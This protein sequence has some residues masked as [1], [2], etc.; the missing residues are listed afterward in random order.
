MLASPR[1][2]FSPFSEQSDVYTLYS[3]NV[4]EHAVDNEVLREPSDRPNKKARVGSEFFSLPEETEHEQES[5]AIQLSLPEEELPST[6]SYLLELPELTSPVD[7]ISSAL[8]KQQTWREPVKEVHIVSE[9]QKIPDAKS[10]HRDIWLECLDLPQ[11]T[12]CLIS[13]DSREAKADIQVPSPYITEASIDAFDRIC[14]RDLEPNHPTQYHVVDNKTLMRNLK[15]VAIGN[16][17][18]LFFF[19]EQQ[20]QFKPRYLNLRT[21][22]LSGK[23]FERCA[24]EFM[25]VGSHFRNMQ[26]MIDR[27]RKHPSKYGQTGI[28]FVCALSEQLSHL[29]A[30]ILD[31][32]EDQLDIPSTGILS[33][34]MGLKNLFAI[35]QRLAE[36]CQSN[37]EDAMN[38]PM[39]YDIPFGSKLLTNLYEC[40]S[41]TDFS[42]PE[43]AHFKTLM[44]ELLVRSS[45]PYF[46]I[47]QQ[48]LGGKADNGGWMDVGMDFN[49]IDPHKEF[50]IRQTENPSDD[51]EYELAGSESTPTFI[52]QGLARHL[53]AAG[54]AYRILQHL[55]KEQ[56]LSET[57]PMIDLRWAFDTEAAAGVESSLIHRSAFQEA[58][59]SFTV[60]TGVTL[61]TDDPALDNRAQLPVKPNIAQF[62]R[63]FDNSLDTVMPIQ[64]TGGGEELT[65]PTESLHLLSI[66]SD[67]AIHGKSTNIDTLATACTQSIESSLRHHAEQD[68]T[69]MDLPM[70]VASELSVERALLWR[71]QQINQKLFKSL[72]E[73]AMLMHHLDTIANHFLLRDGEFVV[74]LKEALFSNEVMVNQGNALSPMSRAAV[75]LRLGFYV[76]KSWPPLGQGL[77]SQLKSVL[78][79]YEASQRVSFRIHRSDTLPNDPKDFHATDFLLLHYD[80]PFPIDR[81]LTADVI[82]KLN[83]VFSHLIRLLRAEAVVN[84]MYKHVRWLERHRGY[85]LPQHTKAQVFVS[86]QRVISALSEA[87]YRVDIKWNALIERIKATSRLPSFEILSSDLQ[88]CV[89]AMLHTHDDLT[90]ILTMAQHLAR[91]LRQRQNDYPDSQG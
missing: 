17:C 21:F 63:P 50:F 8:S 9:P 27:V 3:A 73:H 90:E 64:V 7:V 39:K 12:G 48:W 32:I 33:L 28:A 26:Q 55:H 65:P 78:S 40:L 31:E 11:P 61:G 66:C 58:D 20:R 37:S 18:S 34:C 88:D 24:E 53:L 80:A 49:M 19:A 45:T 16:C 6:D 68:K 5:P 36:F 54:K 25:A 76:D 57:H 47:L 72:F 87:H 69:V 79:S 91:L 15:D 75:G 23:A 77:V 51:L 59:T 41:I 56:E 29:Q 30:S 86:S 10:P 52:T 13:W 60:L 1:R 38:A 89:D 62:I 84:Q 14:R 46:H 82:G 83:N 2:H 22:G 44:R 43:D 4:F 74:R 81:I 85:R 71:C 42:D 70:A 67:P 35:V